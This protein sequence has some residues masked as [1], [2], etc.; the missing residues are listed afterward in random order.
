MLPADR[1]QMAMCWGQ[2]EG[3][4][5]LAGH[6]HQRSDPT[7]TGG[8]GSP[9]L[10][11]TARGAVPLSAAASPGARREPA[12]EG[13]SQH[14]L[15]FAADSVCSVG[16]ENWGSRWSR[17]GGREMQLRCL[18]R[19]N[20]AGKYKAEYLAVGV[21]EPRSQQWLTLEISSS[22]SRTAGTSR[23]APGS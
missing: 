2:Q 10:V 23:R 9:G 19:W 6:G 14:K 7:M 15:P 18:G 21:R 3:S 20:P 16:G 11:W 22:V 1:T 17:P 13:L 8:R 12:G 5:A 4:A